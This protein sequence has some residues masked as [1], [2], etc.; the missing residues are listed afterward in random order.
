VIKLF[1][2]LTQ[3]QPHSPRLFLIGTYDQV[4]GYLSCT[5]V[6]LLLTLIYLFHRRFQTRSA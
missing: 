2:P 1:K 3:L 5:W 4:I 6:F